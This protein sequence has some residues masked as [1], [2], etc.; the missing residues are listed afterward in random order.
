MMFAQFS[1]IVHQVMKTFFRIEFSVKVF[2]KSRKH[3]E[4]GE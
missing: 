3:V 2:I 4:S 1:T